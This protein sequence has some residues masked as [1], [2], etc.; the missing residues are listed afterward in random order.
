MNVA[1]GGNRLA[2]G[3]VI[4]YR[5]CPNEDCDSYKR[6]AK[7]HKARGGEEQFAGWCDEVESRLSPREALRILRQMVR[8]DFNWFDAVSDETVEFARMIVRFL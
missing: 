8:D 2:N 4:G 3:D 5:I 1:A 6:R 7:F